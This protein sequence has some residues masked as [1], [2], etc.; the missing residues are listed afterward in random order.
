[1]SNIGNCDAALTNSRIADKPAFPPLCSLHDAN[2]GDDTYGINIA[3]V[4]AKTIYTGGTWRQPGIREL[5]YAS[6]HTVDTGMLSG[7]KN[8]FHIAH[9]ALLNQQWQPG[10]RALSHATHHIDDIGIES[11]GRNEFHIARTALLY[12]QYHQNQAHP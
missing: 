4:V 12:Q 2:D 9:T 1:M 5:S 10:I 8:E 7:G 6:I 3:S 11:G